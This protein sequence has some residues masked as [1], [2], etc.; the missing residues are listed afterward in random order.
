MLGCSQ[1]AV[2]RA[3]LI[4]KKTIIVLVNVYHDAELVT[5]ELVA[6]ELFNSYKIACFH[7]VKPLKRKKILGQ[8]FRDTGEANLSPRLLISRYFVKWGFAA[9]V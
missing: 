6:I 4:P 2:G 5:I 7:C 8:R 9:L 1:G 3:N